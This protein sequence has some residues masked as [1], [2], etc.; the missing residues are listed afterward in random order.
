MSLVRGTIAEIALF[1]QL[2]SSI[3]CKQAPTVL[4]TIV[5]VAFVSRGVFK[6]ADESLVRDGRFYVP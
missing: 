1:V 2:F 3:V 4:K 6:R 5:S